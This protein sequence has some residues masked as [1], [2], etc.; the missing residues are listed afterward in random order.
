MDRRRAITS[1]AAIVAATA[2]YR[3]NAQQPRV[4]RIG[5][6]SLAASSIPGL[7]ELVQSELR[8]RGYIEGKNLVFE[9]R[10]AGGKLDLLPAMAAELVQA[11]V[12]LIIVNSTAGT[13]AAQ[14]ATKTIPIVMLS[15]TDPLLLGLVPSLSHPGGNTTGVVLNT[16]DI[17][18]KRLQMLVRVV[19]SARR[20][21][22]FYPGEAGTQPVIKQWIQS[23]QETAKALGVA[24]ETFDLGFV[25]E[26]WDEVFR[27]ARE[28]GINAAVVSDWPPY[29]M[30][31]Q[32]L[33]RAAL[34]NR[35]PT[36]FG[37]KE[38]VEAGGLIAYGADINEVIVR[39]MAVVDKI[40]K[41]AKPGDLPI[42]Q[43]TTYNLVVN[44]RTAKALG[45]TI[46]NE[47]LLRADQV[48]Q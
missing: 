39:G 4:Y 9:R 2:A 5:F 42:E 19:P 6:L 17:T 28:R 25:P 12:D 23:N 48:I 20:I 10:Y 22:A 37:F 41:G 14:R 15:V 47:L 46:P 21:A 34:N 33:A 45:L 7:W 3:V 13:A 31:A 40:L 44:L 43:P 18:A 8:K 24:I 30:E 29:F 27:R 35:M 36:L 26:R 16:A 32:Q 1:L 11:K 38:Q